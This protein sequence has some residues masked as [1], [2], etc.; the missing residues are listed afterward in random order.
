M[1]FN[2]VPTKK[3]EELSVEY[4]DLGRFYLADGRRLPSVTTVLGA[5]KSKSL[6]EWRDRV[7][8]DVAD[9]IS[10]QAAVRGEAVHLICENYI[11]NDPDYLL[12]HMPVNIDTFNS[13]K[14]IIDENI[15]NINY[16]EA[17]LYSKYL[18]VAGRV[19]LVAE[20]D[21]KLSIIDFKTSKRKKEKDWIEDYFMQTSAYAVMYEEL[22]GKAVSQ[23]V[24]LIAVDDEDPQIFVEKRDDHIF[25]FI[26]KRKQFKE[27]YGA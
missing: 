7:G 25:K 6:Q 17:P 2:H 15:N 14:K 11:K 20:Y 22:L 3:L 23:L 21:N 27:L 18:E 16:Q 5:F 9:R 1:K 8:H 26:D 4:S 10:R 24:V 12:G 13:I 19:D